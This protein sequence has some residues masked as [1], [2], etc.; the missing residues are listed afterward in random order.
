MDLQNKRVL[1]TGASRGLGAALA[2]SFAAA[3]AKVV[4]VARSAEA[5]TAL[6][7]RLGGVAYA[8]DLSDQSQVDGLIAR[9]EADGGPIDVLVNNAAVETNRLVDE[10]D[11]RDIVNTISLN[12]TT[13]E[14]LTRQVLPGMLQRGRGHLV[15]VSSMTGI[16]N[17][18][19]TSVYSS[20]KAGLTHFSGGLLADLKGTPIGITL[21]EPGPIDTDM[22]EHITASAAVQAAV[23]R[24]E[25]L[26]LVPHMD[27]A[28]LAAAVVSAVKADR[29]HVRFPK[30]GLL[31]YV[32][33]NAPRRM[34]AW[35][36]AGVKAR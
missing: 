7:S 11:E 18:P 29:K 5:I 36:L 10:M 8:V 24:V 17:I 4:L 31:L 1:I 25:K 15:N 16:A 14:R 6:A 12:L 21:V 35:C 34:M 2:E 20:T 13:P 26:R 30:R 3:G 9:I 32:L 33:E 28:T 23:K 22:W 27:P 19:S